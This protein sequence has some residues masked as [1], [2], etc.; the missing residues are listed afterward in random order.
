VEWRDTRL[1]L[2]PAPLTIFAERQVTSAIGTMYRFRVVSP[3]ETEPVV[4]GQ[5][6][7]A[8]DPQQ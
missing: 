7:I 2:L 6:V 8:F 3:H 4:Q 5:V 1:D